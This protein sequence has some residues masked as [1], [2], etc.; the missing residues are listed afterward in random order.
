MPASNAILTS[1]ESSTT[2][3]AD[4]EDEAA[5]NS[6]LEV[7][8][9]NTTLSHASQESSVVSTSLG[10]EE[11][12]DDPEVCR[13]V[14]EVIIAAFQGQPH[15]LPQ[16]RAILSGYSDNYRQCPP[17]RK[18]TSTAKASQGSPQGAAKLQKGS[19]GA[20][21]PT[22]P[23]E[24]EEASNCKVG[25]TSKKTDGTPRRKFACPFN[26]LH[27]TFYCLQNNGTGN[28]FKTCAGSGWAELRHLL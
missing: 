17:K 1:G 5:L 28:R 2:S 27:P 20:K 14:H 11:A 24:D 3:T 8:A 23:P 6:V 18:G 12:G 25:T 9:G 19:H 10:D 15:L 7:A 26:K 22:G 16:I 4:E 13:S 21:V